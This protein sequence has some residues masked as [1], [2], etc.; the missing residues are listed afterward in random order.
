MTLPIDD[1]ILE[2]SNIL[3]K[4]GILSLEQLEEKLNKKRTITKPK[5]KS[6]YDHEYMYEFLDLYDIKSWDELDGKIIDI[7][8]YPNVLKEFKEKDL[9]NKLRKI[10]ITMEY[11]KLIHIT[12]FKKNEDILLL[13]KSILRRNNY[14][15]IHY[16][17]KKNPPLV[18]IKKNTP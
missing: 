9:F 13:L 7:E 5:K 8:K 2:I 6:N 10:L 11:N 16:G 18:K 14:S 17:N 12:N 1:N 4:N 3:K 15:T